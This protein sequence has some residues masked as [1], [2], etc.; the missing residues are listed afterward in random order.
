MKVII[1]TGTPATGK[2][3][4][5]KAIAKQLDFHYVDVKRL[6]KDNNLSEGF[7]EERDCDII[8]E[9]KLSKFIVDNVIKAYNRNVVIDSHLSHF[10]PK[11]NVDV[12]VLTTCEL[13]DLKKR[14]EE[15]DYAYKK[16]KENMMCEIMDIVGEEL[17]EQGYEAFLIDT[18]KELISQIEKLKLNL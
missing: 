15:R 1:V 3:T 9:N 4:V 7:D 18:S 6:I 14:L 16:I 13:D 17:R 2:T 11:K 8:D 12:C 10:I 5:A